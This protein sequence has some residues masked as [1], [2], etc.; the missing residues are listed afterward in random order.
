MHCPTPAQVSLHRVP[1]DN[2]MEKVIV[3]QHA[4]DD[5]METG[6]FAQ[7]R[8][9]LIEGVPLQSPEFRSV[10]KTVPQVMLQDGIKI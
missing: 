7:G 3:I 5:E 9:F 4:V 1:G 8:D 6:F 2:G 10:P